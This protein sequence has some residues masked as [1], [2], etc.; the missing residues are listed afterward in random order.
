MN[1][2]TV[3]WL[4]EAENELADIWLAATDRGAVTAAE[5]AITQLLANDPLNVGKELSEGLRRLERTPLV[6][7]YQVDPGRN[8][9]EVSNVRR[10]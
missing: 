3:E 8:L 9:V 2:F 7:F 6:V 10:Q 4:P 1:R 5:A